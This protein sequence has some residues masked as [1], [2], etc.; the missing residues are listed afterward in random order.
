[1]RRRS[2]SSAH[3]SLVSR[4]RSTTAAG[5]GFGGITGAAGNR[6]VRFSCASSSRRCVGRAIVPQWPAFFRLR[7]KR[8]R[9]KTIVRATMRSV[10][11]WSGANDRSSVV[12]VLHWVNATLISALF[13][14]RTFEFMK[15]ADDSMLAALSQASPDQIHQDRGSSFK[16]LFDTLNHV[17]LAEL[18]WLTRVQGN[19][20]AKLA[21]LP[22]PAD[23]KA[24]AQAWPALHQT[25]IDWVGPLSTGDL[26][27]T[28]T[29]RTACRA[30][31]SGASLA[32]RAAHGE[33]RQLP[34]RAGSHHAAPIGPQTS[35]DRSSDFLPHS[36]RIHDCDRGRGG[37]VSR[38]RH[39]FSFRFR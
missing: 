2:A 10:V 9:R 15:W 5:A 8:R 3:R 26:Q 23:L 24:L 35:R 21:D 4:P 37:A 14:N 32:D 16:S 12:C 17:Y 11:S 1:M 6:K 13:A 36:L 30:R 34:S 20:E 19:P 39:S 27:K 28:L 31:N 7:D 33:S 18:I 29:L 25:W 38:Y 22:A